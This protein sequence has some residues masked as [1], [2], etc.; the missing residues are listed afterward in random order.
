MWSVRCG[1]DKRRRW[2]WRW[3]SARLPS[4]HAQGTPVYHPD[5]SNHQSINMMT[6]PTCSKNTSVPSRPVQSSINQY[7]DPANMLKDHQCTIQACSIINQYD[8]PTNMF[9]EHQCTIQTCPII[10]QSIWWPSNILQEHQCT[11]Q[12]CSIINQS[13]INQSILLPSQ[14]ASG[15]PVYHP[16]LF[17]HKSINMMTQPTYSRT[18]SVPS[19]PVQSSINQYDYPP[20]ILQ[21]H[22]CTIQTYLLSIYDLPSSRSHV[23]SSAALSHSMGFHCCSSPSPT[24]SR[25][26]GAGGSAGTSAAGA[27]ASSTLFS[28]TAAVGSASSGPTSKD[29]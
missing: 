13:I 22:Q 9:Q 23:S 19:R 14:H 1:R 24:P 11:I 4:Q 18:T 12:T 17:N 10:N 26:S 25:I 29:R 15:T 3:S 6:Q 7:D 20:N 8:D 16:D 21:E 28:S 27:A 2:G 5:L